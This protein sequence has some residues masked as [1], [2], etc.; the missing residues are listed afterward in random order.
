MPKRG[1][2]RQHVETDQQN[3]VKEQ[4]MNIHLLPNARLDPVWQW[5]WREGIN[6]GLTTVRTMVDLL[7]ENPDLTFIRGLETCRRRRRHYPAR[8]GSMRQEDQAEPGLAW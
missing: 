3:P 7:E 4:A 2:R 8:A 1:T 5:D 6:E